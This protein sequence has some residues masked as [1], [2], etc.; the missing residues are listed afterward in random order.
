MA[1]WWKN[2]KR[3]KKKNP[4]TFY[5]C[6]GHLCHIMRCVWLVLHC[7]FYSYY[8]I[9]LFL[10]AEKL[11][12]KRSS[13]KVSLI[14][15]VQWGHDGTVWRPVMVS[16]QREAS[17][18]NGSTRRSQMAQFCSQ[19]TDN[20][21]SFVWPDCQGF[22]KW[23]GLWVEY[24]KFVAQANLEWWS[25]TLFLGRSVLYGIP[26]SPRNMLISWWISIKINIL[27]P[28][29]WPLCC[30]MCLEPAANMR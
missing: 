21:P 29:M 13:V 9:V 6:C 18:F 15:E 22:I 27:Q 19:V 26:E 12:A 28:I 2:I 24:C 25:L 23:H 11:L 17:W 3:L 7:E 10:W 4:L 8:S 16:V 20:R 30:K 5:W 1:F 14:I